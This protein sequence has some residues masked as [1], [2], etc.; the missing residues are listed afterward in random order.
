MERERDDWDE[1]L[2]LEARCGI[3]LPYQGRIRVLHQLLDLYDLM[4]M[5]EEEENQG[6]RLLQH[7]I[8]GV[9]TPSGVKNVL[10]VLHAS[11]SS[12]LGLRFRGKRTSVFLHVF[13]INSRKKSQKKEK[14]KTETCWVRVMGKRLDWIMNLEWAE[15]WRKPGSIEIGQTWILL[16][17]FK[18]GWI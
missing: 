1:S 9:K 5:R 18:K 7:L 2:V 13:Y 10:P 17:G 15:T 4:E 8:Q 14:K 6:H 11:V 12:F 3:I 16:N